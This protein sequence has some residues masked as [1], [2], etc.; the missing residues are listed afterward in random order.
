MNRAIWKKAVGD[1]WLQLLIC[2]LIL[3]A[4][5]WLFVWLMSQIDL[6]VWGVMVRAMPSFFRRLSDIPIPAMVTSAGRLTILFVHPITLL[7][8]IGW[9]VGR[10][11][12]SISGE[13]DRGTMDLVLSL[14][15]RRF[16]VM[17]APAVVA[18]V[19]AFVLAG[20]LLGGIALGLATCEVSG[21]VSTRAFLP[22]A[23][24]LACMVFCFTG[25]TTLVSS[26]GR[27]RW[28]TIIIAGGL[29]VVSFIIEIVRQFW[30]AGTWLKYGTFLSAFSPRSLILEPEAT[31][32][33]AWPYN[34]PLISLGLAAYAVAA[35]VLTYRDIPAAR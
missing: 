17:L 26:F 24:N 5:G 25:M 14:P 22:G 9:A 29:Y 2:G 8:A 30:S 18:T 27:N 19:G 31:G 3:V 13:I 21:E 16:T 34:L 4:F 35:I 23:I 20:A 28:R 32:L 1:A 7:V 10:G 12:D 6:G 33:L 15:V 11:S